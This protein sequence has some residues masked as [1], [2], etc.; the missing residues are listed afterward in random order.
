MADDN[1][2]CALVQ[3]VSCAPQFFSF[4]M[5][6]LRLKS[7]AKIIVMGPVAT[8]LRCLVCINAG[9]KYAIIF[10]DN[11]FFFIER[12]S[13]QIHYTARTKRVFSM[14]MVAPIHH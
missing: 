11:R 5:A 2:F 7:Y 4:A 14:A 9:N 13:H 6:L 12:R 10:P 3:N 1:E 8:A